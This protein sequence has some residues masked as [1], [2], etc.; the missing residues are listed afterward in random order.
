M[1][2]ELDVWKQSMFL[3]EK[4]YV[5]TKSFPDYEKFGL[6]QQL[7]RSAVSV[8]SNIAEGAA[9]GT[10]K[11][12]IHF[13][14]IGL[15]SISEVETQLILAKRLQYREGV[16]DFLIDAETVKKLLFGLIKALKKRLENT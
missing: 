11:E 7:R 5:A 4:I 1:H 8:P 14:H 9:R 16:E 3:A 12:F 13:L 2:K 10:T 15:G 6:G